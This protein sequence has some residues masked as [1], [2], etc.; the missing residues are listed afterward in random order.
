MVSVESVLKLVLFIS[1]KETAGNTM[2]IDEFNTIINAVNIDYLKQRYGLPEEY[3]PAQPMPKMG[4]EITKKLLDDMRQLKVRMGI[5]EP[6]LQVGSYGRSDIPSN[7][8]H[9]SSAR[10]NEITTNSCDTSEVVIKP[11]DIELLT[12]AQIGDRVSNS[13]TMPTKKNPC[14]AVYS[15]YFQFY[16]YNLSLVELTYLR[17]PL[18]PIYGYTINEDTDEYIYDS[19]TSQ[20]FEFPADC[21]TD[22]VR[23]T[24]G[25]VQINLKELQV[26]QYNEMQ[27]DKGV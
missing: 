9:L 27:K 24:L 16:P 20:D 5:D 12:D 1:N 10:Y 25:Y 13:V 2:K 18:T 4:Y 6:F 19:S 3:T 14:M 17:F 7:F 15:T 23:L 26:I 21:L 22:I 11:R 8:L